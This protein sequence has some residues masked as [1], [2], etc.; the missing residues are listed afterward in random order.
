MA[1]QEAMQT[2]MITTACLIEYDVNIWSDLHRI[3]KFAIEKYLL[4]KLHINN[5][6]K[7]TKFCQSML[8]R[9]LKVMNRLSNFLL[10]ITIFKTN[11]FKPNYLK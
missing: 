9:K 4:P 1:S 5:L 11:I 2:I 6:A 10:F 8:P 3:F 7:Q